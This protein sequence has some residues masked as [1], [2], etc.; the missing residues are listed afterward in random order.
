MRRDICFADRELELASLQLPNSP[1]AEL[2][3]AYLAAWPPDP[4]NRWP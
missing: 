1:P 4:G 2:Q 3:D